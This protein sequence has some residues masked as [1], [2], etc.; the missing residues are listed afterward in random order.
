MFALPFDVDNVVLFIIEKE[1]HPLSVEDSKGD[2]HNWGSMR[3]KDLA[4]ECVKQDLIPSTGNILTALDKNII[5]K[6]ISD[7]DYIDIIKRGQSNYVS[8]TTLGMAF[9]YEITP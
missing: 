9:V 4:N 1:N 6:L 8:L 7:W 2:K 5:Q 3:K